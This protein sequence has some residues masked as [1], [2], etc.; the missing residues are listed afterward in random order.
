MARHFITKILHFHNGNC[1]LL[2]QSPGGV[3]REGVPPWPQSF[4]KCVFSVGFHM[5]LHLACNVCLML[6]WGSGTHFI[7]FFSASCCF[8]GRVAKTPKTHPFAASISFYKHLGSFF[9]FRGWSGA[10]N[11]YSNR[12]PQNKYSNRTLGLICSI[13][14]IPYTPMSLLLH[15]NQCWLTN[16]P[17][18]SL[19]RFPLPPY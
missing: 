16:L 3:L 11:K 5:E 9:W 7:L 13:P 12:S 14:I 18:P 6:E 4:I 10:P 17:H 1:P 19:L 8:S 2:A 15:L